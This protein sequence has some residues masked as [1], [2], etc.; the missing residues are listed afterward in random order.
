MSIRTNPMKAVPTLLKRL[1]TVRKL[2]DLHDLES[3]LINIKDLFSMVKKNEDELLDTLTVVDGYLRNSNIEKLMEEK[4][5]ICDRIRISTRKLLPTDA[6][7]SSEKESPPSRDMKL[8]MSEHMKRDFKVIYDNLDDVEKRCFL[9][10]LFFNK[11]VAIEK[12]KIVLWWIKVGFIEMKIEKTIM[13]SGDY[14]FDKLCFYGVILPRYI[15][16]R[17]SV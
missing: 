15:E 17:S 11:N 5:K 6:I 12:R 1:G 8:N 2:V 13:E 10:L 7:Q 9:S 4:K 3:A 14:V 16:K